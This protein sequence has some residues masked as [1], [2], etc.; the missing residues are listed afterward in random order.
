MKNRPAFLERSVPELTSEVNL[1]ISCKAGLTRI[2]L[3]NWVSTKVEDFSV[4][5][6]DGRETAVEAC[7]FDEGSYSNPDPALQ[8]LG[9]ETLHDFGMAVVIPRRPLETAVSYHV[10]M[11][12]NGTK[13]DWSFSTPQNQPGKQAQVGSVE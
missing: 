7:A 4:Q 5:R 11:T 10:T 12:V 3:G 1:R 6:I 9:R 8:A 13:Y 2:Q